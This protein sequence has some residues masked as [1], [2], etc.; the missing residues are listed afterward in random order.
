MVYNGKRRL[1][2][3]LVVNSGRHN[4]EADAQHAGN[5]A[6]G[7]PGLCEGSNMSHCAQYCRLEWA[8]LSMVDKIHAHFQFKGSSE[9]GS[10]IR[11]FRRVS[12]QRSSLDRTNRTMGGTIASSPKRSKVKGYIGENRMISKKLLNLVLGSLIASGLSLPVMAQQSTQSTTTTTSQDPAYVQ[13]SQT[14]QSTTTTS[15]SDPVYVQPTQIT[16][17]ETTTKTKHHKVK[18]TSQTTTTSSSPVIQSQDTSTTTTT[19]R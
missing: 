18:A 12:G 19:T 17:T 2:L 13:P 4:H 15:S 7:S 10:T 5:T 11:T 1:Y 3:Q 16:S 8:N 6:F 14:T 9:E